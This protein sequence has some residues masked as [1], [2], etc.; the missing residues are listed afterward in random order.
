VERNVQ[1]HVNQG[2][3]DMEIKNARATSTLTTVP[4][5]SNMGTWLP[6]PVAGAAYRGYVA[7]A[8]EKFREFFIWHVHTEPVDV[9]FAGG[10]V[11]TKF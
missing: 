4:A 8:L 11:P 10:S 2:P 3:V 5:G 6:K 9:P 1:F 7:G